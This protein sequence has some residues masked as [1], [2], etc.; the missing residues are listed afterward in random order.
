VDLTGGEFA[1]GKVLLADAGGAFLRIIPNRAGKG[2]RVKTTRD[3]AEEKRQEKLELVR[4]QVES[5]ALVIRQMTDEERR[6]YPPRA[7]DAPRQSR[8]RA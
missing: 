1:A 2:E 3:R 6:R 7:H 8:R 4:E 5:G